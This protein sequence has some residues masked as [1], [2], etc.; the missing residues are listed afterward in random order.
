MPESG[1]FFRRKEAPNKMLKIN[2]NLRESV[3]I[4]NR[5]TPAT[6]K[7]AALVFLV[8]YF[9]SLRFLVEVIQGAYLLSEQQFSISSKMSGDT[10]RGITLLAI[11]PLAVWAIVKG[12]LIAKLF[13]R[14]R[15]AKNVLSVIA[16]LIFLVILWAHTMHPENASMTPS[17][18]LEHIAE[19]VA[20]VLLLTPRSRSWFRSKA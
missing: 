11:A 8:S 17:N 12:F 3:P 1:T 7:I 19:V 6:T 10:L 15:W 18:N 16:V 4:L 5:N 2:A 14:R 13:F 9:M 20:V